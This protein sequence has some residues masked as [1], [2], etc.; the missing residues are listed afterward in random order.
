[1]SHDDALYDDASTRELSEWTGT[2]LGQA[3]IRQEREQLDSLLAKLYGPIAIQYGAPD[4]S[5]FLQSSNAIRRI[6]SLSDKN[7]QEPT[8]SR[9]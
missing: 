3:L 5:Q 2:T 4:F 7:S 8:L 9:I 6:H 1:M